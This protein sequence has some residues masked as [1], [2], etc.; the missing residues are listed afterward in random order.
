MF[1][2]GFQGLPNRGAFPK[3]FSCGVLQLLRNCGVNHLLGSFPRVLENT[4]K[5]HDASAN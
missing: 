3:K 1:V 4:Q 2:I 5:L